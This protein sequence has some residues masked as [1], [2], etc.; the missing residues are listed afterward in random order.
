MA[1]CEVGGLGVGNCFLGGCFSSDGSENPLDLPG[2]SS[3]FGP[4]PKPFGDNVVFFSSGATTTKA[5]R[6]L[7]CCFGNDE[8]LKSFCSFW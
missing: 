6:M 4:S 3:C 2:F 1:G 5:I 8:I 7:I